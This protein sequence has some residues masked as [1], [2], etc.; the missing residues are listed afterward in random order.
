MIPLSLATLL[1]G[2]AAQAVIPHPL[3]GVPTAELDDHSVSDDDGGHLRA[4]AVLQIDGVP[5]KNA[6][7]N[8]SRLGWGA[9]TVVVPYIVARHIEAKPINVEIA[10]QYLYGAPIQSLVSSARGT[11]QTV[12]GS[13]TFTPIA[14]H[15]YRVNGALKPGGSQIWIEDSDPGQPVTEKLLSHD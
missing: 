8:A 2:C 13:V 7:N 10:G 6:I 1:A 14:N 15:I 4:F 9:S 5:V 12:D 3:P 11:N